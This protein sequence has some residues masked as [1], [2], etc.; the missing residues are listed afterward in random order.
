MGDKKYGLKELDQGL[1]NEIL[2]IFQDAPNSSSN[3]LCNVLIEL[4]FIH[5]II[6]SFKL[7]N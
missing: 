5:H 4:E 3:F 1:Q 7:Y 6:H 2:P